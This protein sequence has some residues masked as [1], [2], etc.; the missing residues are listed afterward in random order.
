MSYAKKGMLYVLLAAIFWGSSGVAAQYIMEQSQISAPF[1]T[2]IR[3]LFSGFILLT[4]SFM[5]GDKIFAMFK[6]RRDAISLVIFSLFGALLVQFTF[7]V[8]IEKSNAATATILQFLSPTIIVMWFAAILKKRP[9]RYVIMAVATSLI[10][11][12][13]LV[14]HGNPTSLSISGSALFW[15]IASAFA[16]A[17]YTTYPSKLIGQYGTLPIVGWSMLIGGAALLPFYSGQHSGVTINSHVLMAFFYLVVVGTALTFSIYLKGAQMI[18]GPKAS[19]L[20]CAEPLSSALL[21]LALLGIS[22][23]L[24]DWLGTLLI[25]SSVALISL[26]SRRK[27][28]P[29]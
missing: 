24:P 8:A 16:A 2:M 22:F 14:T 26:D 15:G 25:L 21:S 4:L 20:S 10:G 6:I 9:S 28:R 29:A 23:T 3:L 7:L 11:T 5:Q 1:L 27:V 17:F 12:F 18:G 13:L 19:I